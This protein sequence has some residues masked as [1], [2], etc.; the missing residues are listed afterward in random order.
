M[1]SARALSL[2]SSTGARPAKEVLGASHTAPPSTE[3]LS[4]SLS[5]GRLR[6]TRNVLLM[7]FGVLLALLVLCGLNALEIISQLQTSNETILRDFLQEQQRLDKV[8]S[9]IYLSGTYLRDYLLEPDPEKAEQSRMA[10]ATERAQA[11]SIL[12]GPRL[13]SGTPARNEMYAALQREI[14]DY[15]RSMDPVLH[16][17]PAERHSRGYQF[18]RDEVF[19]RR[20]NTLNIAD[21][22][23]TVNQ[24]QLLE[25]D[26]RLLSLFSS[27][28]G[29]LMLAL[30]VMVLL[31]IV[32]AT[33]STIHLLRM[34]RGTIAHL[35]EVSAARQELRDLSA[36]LVTT[37]ES[38]RRNL[39]RELHDAVGQ[40]LS[41]V[42]FEL[43]DLA[44]VLGEGQNP[45]RS[46][47]NRIRELVESSLAMIRNMARLLRPTMLDDLGLAAAL[48]GLAR[49]I[50]RSTG[51]RISVEAV[52]LSEELPDEHKICLFRIAQEALN[53]VCRHANAD[54]V[55]IALET[56]GGQVCMAI[57]DDG[58]GFRSGHAKGLGLIGM[59]ERVE[60]LGGTLAILSGPGQGTRIEV[61]LPFVKRG[62]VA[63]S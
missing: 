2:H 30:L 48:E 49:D 1:P 53:N 16:W 5:E 44:V 54:S 45:L 10:L 46:R 62:F 41:A 6:K 24:Q 32:Q 56:S 7:G 43:H 47:V 37:Q 60:S 52:N 35:I 22:I 33:A 18:L 28:R 42:Q 15:W 29:R 8:R 25:R 63:H 14:D 58:R 13:L 59:Q 61:A 26:N 51:V 40:S 50:S 36:K 39:S 55:E 20:S 11:A 12:S 57:A 34:E 9:A 17:K 31:G 23:A 4:A 38:E 3:S 19:P 27:F 21:N